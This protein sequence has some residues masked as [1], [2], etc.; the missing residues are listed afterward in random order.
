MNINSIVITL[1]DKHQIIIDI[2]NTYDEIMDALQEEID[3]LEAVAIT[4]RNTV[5][6]IL[7]TQSLSTSNNWFRLKDNMIIKIN[8]NCIDIKV[9]N[10]ELSKYNDVLS[11]NTSEGSQMTLEDAITV[12]KM[13]CDYK[14]FTLGED[15][16]KYIEITYNNQ[17]KPGYTELLIFKVYQLVR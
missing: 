9:I 5:N 6:S 3:N 10:D 15:R 11:I 16:S 13:T 2:S 4:S 7:R 1:E 8:K 17:E 14:K 12:L